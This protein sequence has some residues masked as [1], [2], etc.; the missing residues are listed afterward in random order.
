MQDC[1]RTHQELVW[2]TAAVATEF[3]REL[4]QQRQQQ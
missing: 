4:A 2:A 3:Q 1:A